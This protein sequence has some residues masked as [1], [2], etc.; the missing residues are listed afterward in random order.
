VSQARDGTRRSPP[1][2][3]RAAGA[4]RRAF[5]FLPPSLR[6]PTNQPPRKP[7]HKNTGQRLKHLFRLDPQLQPLTRQAVAGLPSP[8]AARRAADAAGRALPDGWPP[9][10]A[11]HLAA[12][13][14]CFGGNKNDN[15]DDARAADAAYR[16]YTAP[17]GP[18]LALLDVLR[19]RPDEAWLAAAF[20]S[21]LANVRWLAER[22][23][24][25]ALRQGRG[26]AGGTAA[27]LGG[28]EDGA[29]SA[30]SGP[31]KVEALGGFL[32]N[33]FSH[34]G[35]PKGRSG[36]AGRR[37]AGLAIMVALIKAYF[38]L[39]NVSGC[40]Q[41]SRTV[42]GVLAARDPTLADFPA[43]HRVSY[44][45]Y[46]GRIAIFTERFDSAAEHL[47]AAH[48]GCL[49]GAASHRR[50][51]LR[52]LVPVRMLLGE[53]PGRGLLAGA[54]AGAGGGAA[55][56][57]VQAADA[58]ADAAASSS[59]LEGDYGALADC[60][61][62]GDVGG[63]RRALAANRL[64]YARSGT[65]LLLERLQ[66]PCLR[67]LFRRAH[68]AW[69]AAVVSAAGLPP[70]GGAP[71]PARANQLPVALLVSALEAQGAF[72]EEDAEEEA[73]LRE[74]ME[75]QAEEEGQQQRRQQPQAQAAAAAGG[76]LLTPPPPPPALDAALLAARRAQRREDAVMCA[77]ANLIAR[78]YVRGYV[79]YRSKV[80][81]LSKQNP[82][83]GF[84]DKWLGEVM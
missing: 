50:K 7:L 45:Y 34:L 79:A 61:R 53:L 28:A 47:G 58:A 49:R 51:I 40:A 71:P 54:D 24:A 6:Q 80:L 75:E 25:A 68:G 76:A 37:R 72:A 46:M 66:L 1:S 10:V 69:A 30:P 35:A 3:A 26:P 81:V 43:G 2:R 20:E 16:L 27:A 74:E 77:L 19:D 38:K 13:Q 60:L 11:G 64:R 32:Q 56:G 39:N 31:S 55:G 63:L 36:Q 73:L 15:N 44:H 41:A 4:Q 83:P 12:A 5:P 48:A 57:A 22:A 62:R 59:S 17:D 78:D 9:V 23:D 21:L 8:L 67:R 18:A 70:G 84:S 33:A 82:F 52:F 65:Y 29:A 42:Q 14:A